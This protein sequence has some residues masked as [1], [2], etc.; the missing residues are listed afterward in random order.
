[1]I[2]KLKKDYNPCHATNL[3]LCPLKTSENQ[4]FSDV[5]RRYRKRP[6]TQNELMLFKELL[7]TLCFKIAVGCLQ[8]E[9]ATTF[10][11]TFSSK[12]CVLK[13]IIF[14]KIQFLGILEHSNITNENVPVNK[15]HFLSCTSCISV[16]VNKCQE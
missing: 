1:M 15:N 6:V 8:L 10:K 5:F 2:L 16:K 11:I 13:R 14:V 12:L 3:F 4:K 7:K 9:T